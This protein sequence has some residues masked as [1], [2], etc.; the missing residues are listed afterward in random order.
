MAHPIIHWEIG[1]PDLGK[2]KLFYSELFGWTMTPGG[3]NYMLVQGEQGS[4]G[5]GLMQ[6]PEGVPAY[7]TVY[8]QVDDLDASL[9]RAAEL[10]GKV[11]MGPMP[12]PG[13][14]AMAMFQDV[15]G[16]AVG[17]MTLSSVSA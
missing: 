9:A 15:Q 3:P 2:L 6:S 13:V 5:G 4:V 7:V 14:G 16:N 11:L 8:V 10:G 12:I 1:G 17:M